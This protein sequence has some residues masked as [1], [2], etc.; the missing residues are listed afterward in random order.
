[1]SPVA[2]MHADMCYSKKKKKT[3]RVGWSFHIA[4]TTRYTHPRPYLTCSAVASN[5]LTNSKNL[6]VHTLFIAISVNC[7]LSVYQTSGVARLLNTYSLSWKITECY[8]WVCHRTGS[9]IYSPYYACKRKECSHA[10]QYS[11]STKR[12]EIALHVVQDAEE[13]DVVAIGGLVPLH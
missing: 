4:L 7:Y 9:T 12:Q 1:M 10:V 3:L 6:S 5:V 13:V 2:L 11:R 8:L